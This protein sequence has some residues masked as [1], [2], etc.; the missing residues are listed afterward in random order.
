MST[1]EHICSLPHTKSSTIKLGWS[2]LNT[3]TSTTLWCFDRCP[4]RY[5]IVPRQTARETKGRTRQH[6]AIDEIRTG[7]A[8]LNDKM[9]YCPIVWGAPPILANSIALMRT[10]VCE[11]RDN[12]KRKLGGNLLGQYILDDHDY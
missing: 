9:A 2:T 12:V 3:S 7:N 11:A 5:T 6:L 8:D 1:L 10:R 4:R